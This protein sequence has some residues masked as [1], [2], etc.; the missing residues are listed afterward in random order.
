MVSL[1]GRTIYLILSEEGNEGD[2]DTSPNG[3]SNLA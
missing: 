3:R 2:V 1:I